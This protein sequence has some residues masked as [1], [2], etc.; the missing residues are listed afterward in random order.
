MKSLLFTWSLLLGGAGTAWAQTAPATALPCASLS[1]YVLGSDKPLAGV[2]VAVPG[3]RLVAITNGEG[4]F[5]LATANVAQPVLVFSAAGYEPQTL[6]PT[7]CA[8]AHVE[9][10]LLPGTRI[11]QRGKRKGFIMKTG[12]P[13]P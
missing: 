11:K 12:T 13:T 7:T 6:T 1:G 2:T 4:Y 10:Q 5:T 3:T 9:M 8:D